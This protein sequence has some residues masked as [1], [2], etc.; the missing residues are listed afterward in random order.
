MGHSVTFMASGDI[1]A[2]VNKDI[3][4]FRKANDSFMLFPQTLTLSMHSGRFLFLN[5]SPLF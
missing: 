4:S 2:L 3:S 5:L 1:S